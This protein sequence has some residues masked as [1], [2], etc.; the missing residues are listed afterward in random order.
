MSS[1]RLPPELLDHVVDLLHDTEDTLRN[2]SLVSKSWIPRTRKHLFADIKFRS[3]DDLQ[4]W[5]EMFPDPLTSPAYHA[6]T[7]TVKCIRNVTAADAEP[8]GWITGFSSVV[9]F[10]VIGQGLFTVHERSA[11]VPFHG[12]SPV[13]KSL[14]VVFTFLPSSRILDLILSFPLLEDLTAIAHFGIS[15]SSTVGSNAPPTIAQP[16]N[17]PA[18]T[19]SLNLSTKGGMET[20]V[21][22][23]LSLPGGI[24]FRKLTVKWL[25]WDDL[26]LTMALVERCS[27]TLEY[28]QVTCNTCGTSI[29]HL[30]PH[31]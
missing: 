4:S 28:I 24:H 2:C 18:F 30:R 10:R 12:F 3:A 22:R 23:L 11:L 20:I 6:H 17:S 19:G 9:R 5:K 25:H 16:S 31:G 1:R 14:H 27:H 21:H 15:T 13:M 7:L 29:R 8:G 26:A